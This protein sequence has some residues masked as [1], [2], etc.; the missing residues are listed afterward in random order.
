MEALLSVKNSSRAE[1]I[2]IHLAINVRCRARGSLKRRMIIQRLR[3][4]IHGAIHLQRA[5]HFED[6]R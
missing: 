6:Q 3:I 2:P 5:S 1:P 4:G